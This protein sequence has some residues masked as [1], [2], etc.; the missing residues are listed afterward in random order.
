MDTAAAR[1][2]ERAEPT[3]QMIG[4]VPAA[5]SLM[6][7]DGRLILDLDRYIPFLLSAIGNKWSSSSSTAYLR[8]FGVGVTEW[9]IMAMLAIE[10]GVNAYRAC[11]VIGLD[12]AAT[13]R[14][15]K[16][17]EARGLVVSW[18]ETPG[19]QRKNLELT[20]AGWA[21][22]DRIIRIARKREALLLSDLDPDEV[23]ILAG[24]LRRILAR[25][26]DLLASDFSDD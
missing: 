10:P 8:K 5:P 20:E 17:L 25:L 16:S 1:G 19:A 26:P 21:V 18:V 24:Y 2:R 11:Q 7:R 23:A 4:A 15:L 6:E 13:S 22:H 12:K 9:R 14:A 3:R